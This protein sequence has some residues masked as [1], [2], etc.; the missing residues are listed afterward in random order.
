MKTESK[1][2]NLFIEKKESLTIRELAKQIKSDYRI[3]YT[4]VQKL[5]EK[6]VILAQTV[7][8]STLCS[9]NKDYY[10]PEIYIVE[11][12]RKETLLKN[13][14]LEVL[15]TEIMSNLK[16]AQFTFLLFGSYAKGKQTKH[17]DIDLCFI[18]NDKDFEQKIYNIVSSIPLKIHPL[19]FSEKEFNS[20]K[21]SREPNIIR[22][23]IQNT[24]ILY[25][26]E[27]YYRLK[28][29]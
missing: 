4:A 11:E 19:I 23:I 7:G 15:Y 8:K 1:I 29:L 20:M 16:T 10:G 21:F 2:I 26:I 13:K 14:N 27:P 5:L 25:G 24:Y 28:N 6:K 17:S 22:E 12:K 18:S 9:L 3:T